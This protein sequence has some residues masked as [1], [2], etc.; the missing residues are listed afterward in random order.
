M[1]GNT[2]NLTRI[3]EVKIA[4]NNLQQEG[5]DLTKHLGKYSQLWSELEVLR[6]ST[7][8]PSTLEERHEQDKVFG[9]LLTLN[10]SFNEVIRHILRAKE[11][12]DYDDVCAQLQKEL[13]S[14]GLFGEKREIS[15]ASKAEK[16]EAPV[17]NKTAYKLGGDRLVTCEYCKKQGYSKSNCWVLYTHLR[18]PLANKFNQGRAHEAR[19][20][21]VQPNST[22]SMC[23]GE[24]GRAMISTTHDVGS[25]SQA[26]A[27]DDPVIRK[28]DIEALIKTLNANSGNNSINFLNSTHIATHHIIKDARLISNVKPALGSVVNANGNRIPIERV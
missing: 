23:M 19:A 6:P 26:L 2:S 5:M 1:D 8:N 17:A 10:P 14:D 24:D 22:V 12:T 9:L 18:P 27:H 11:L 3:F 4:I 7:T 25:T 21:E 16:V 13:G 28:S 15:M 20:K